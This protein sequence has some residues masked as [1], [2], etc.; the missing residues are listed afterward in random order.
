MPGP[1][2]VASGLDKPTG[3]ASSQSFQ[4]T[5]N[6]ALLTEMRLVAHPLIPLPCHA[7]KKLLTRLR[8]RPGPP[9]FLGRWRRRRLPEVGHA[10]AHHAVQALRDPVLIDHLDPQ[11]RLWI[12]AE[13]LEHYV[14]PCG[15]CVVPSRAGENNATDGITTVSISRRA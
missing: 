2:E 14:L 1:Y 8:V 11:T 13:A 7:T 9:D 5:C 15:I 12:R 6:W 3:S 10:K 4:L